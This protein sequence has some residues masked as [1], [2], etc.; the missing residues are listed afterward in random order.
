MFTA[1]CFFLTTEE[2]F[3]NQG[4]LKGKALP[5]YQ[6]EYHDSSG[7]RGMSFGRW[8]FYYSDSISLASNEKRN[9]LSF[10]PFL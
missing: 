5:D 2:C 3:Q 1:F 9:A 4:F 7:Q 6:V 8:R 10:C